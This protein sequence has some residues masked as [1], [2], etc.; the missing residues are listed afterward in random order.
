MITWLILAAA[1][2]PF[3]AAVASKAA[4]RGFDNNNPRS[5][6]ARQQGWRARANAAQTNLFEGLPF[7]YAAVLY[8]LYANAPAGL[9][10]GLM[11]AW[12]ATRLVYLGLYIA[13]WG[14]VRSLVW[15]IALALNI[16]ILFCGA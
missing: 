11:A 6:L 10:A 13:G 3:I 14:N 2:L 15:A 8:A 7:F 1:I 4:G 16:A 12:I 5:W 9:L